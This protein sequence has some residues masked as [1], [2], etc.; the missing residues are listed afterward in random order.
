MAWV[1]S[2]ILFVSYNRAHNLAMR[3][4]TNRA[5][6]AL[7]LISL[8]DIITS[9]LRSIRPVN[10]FPRHIAISLEHDVCCLSLLIFLSYFH[11][12]LL[13]VIVYC[14]FVLCVV[15]LSCEL[16]GVL[17]CVRVWI[18]CAWH[19]Y[20]WKVFRQLFRPS[21]LPLFRPVCGACRRE[22][23]AA[24]RG[25]LWRHLWR[26]ESTPERCA[27]D[28]ARRP[29]TTRPTTAPPGPRATRRLR[30]GDNDAVVASWRTPRDVAQTRRDIMRRWR[31]AMARSA[32]ATSSG[33]RRR[34]GSRQAAA[35]S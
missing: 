14:V 15:Y 33:R 24:P 3:H 13:S 9:L 10:S 35:T 11:G 32:A 31:R 28:V 19:L 6:S 34:A 20:V 25:R 8:Q 21:P 12:G 30:H 22:T 4:S 26:A 27:A 17:L 29:G 7:A 16:S 18:M 1:S 23:T 5:D 2:I